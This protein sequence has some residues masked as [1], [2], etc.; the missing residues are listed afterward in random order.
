MKLPAPPNRKR[1]CIARRWRYLKIFLL[2]FTRGS[3][4]INPYQLTN[5]KATP[6]TLFRL[7]YRP[8]CIRKRHWGVVGVIYCVPTYDIYTRHIGWSISFRLFCILTKPPGGGVVR[9]DSFDKPPPPTTPR[10]IGGCLE[11]PFCPKIPRQMTSCNYAR[12]K[13]FSQRHQSIRQ[14]DK[15]SVSSDLLIYL[16]DI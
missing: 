15:T 12:I 1:S 8:S 3:S 6:R 10:A 7:W 9:V 5:D 11:P 13:V 14:I 16:Y 2:G 4:A